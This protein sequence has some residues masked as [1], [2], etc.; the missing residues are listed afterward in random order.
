MGIMIEISFIIL[1]GISLKSS[2]LYEHNFILVILLFNSVT[3]PFLQFKLPV[4]SK[5]FIPSYSYMF[6]Y[7]NL[8][9]AYHA[10]SYIQA[11]VHLTMD[12]SIL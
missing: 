3:I 1:F 9:A 8:M 10:N 6:M 2:L 4:K 5:Y 11:S 7:I 12:V